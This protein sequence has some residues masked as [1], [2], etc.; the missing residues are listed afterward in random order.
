MECIRRFLAP[1][2]FDDVEEMRNLKINT[3]QPYFSK[4]GYYEK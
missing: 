3:Y 1:S 4:E 2:D